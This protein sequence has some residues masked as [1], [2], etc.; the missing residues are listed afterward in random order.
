ML[1]KTIINIFQSSISEN[2]INESL[3]ANQFFTTS[4]IRTAIQAIT[5][6]IDHITEP[7]FAFSN[8]KIGVLAAGNIPFVGFFDMYNALLTGGQVFVKPS[9]RDPLMRIFGDLVHIVDRLPHQVDIILAMGS[10]QTMQALGDEYPASQLI[11][12]GTEHSAAVLTGNESSEELRG[13][14]DDIF[15]HSSMGCRSVSHLHLPRAYPL[16]RLRF[17]ARGQALPAA[18]Y[19]N[20]RQQKAISTMRGEK[21]IDGEFYLLAEGFH[22]SIATVGYTF[23]DNIEKIDFGSVKLK[24]IVSQSSIADYLPLTP[25]EFGR[26]QFPKFEFNEALSEILLSLPS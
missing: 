15:L 5:Q 7:Q 3:A 25:T 13:L 19:D 21:F 2:L 24:S 8:L 1:N 11:L 12:R 4:S 16:D 6:E 14:A 20:Y 23:Y 18:W 17:D 10:D 9:R 22:S 26:G